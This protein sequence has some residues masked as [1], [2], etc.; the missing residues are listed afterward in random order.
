[1][2]GTLTARK[3]SWHRLTPADA[4]DESTVRGATRVALIISCA[5]LVAAIGLLDYWTGPD[6]SLAVLFLVPVV[7]AAW[8]AGRTQGI[9]VAL[10]A[11]MAWHVSNAL[12]FPA[13]SSI[14][15]LWNEVTYF[16]FF[17]VAAILA[18]RLRSAM[19][20]DQSLAITD[21]LTGAANGAAFFEATHLELERSRRTGQPVTIAL[22]GVDDFR[23]VVSLL[24]Q[25]QGDQALRHVADAL[26]WNLRPTDLLARLAGD[27]FGLLLP[28]TDEHTAVLLI[29]RL[30]RVAYQKT[31]NSGHPVTLSVGA[32][33]LLNP[34]EVD[35]AARLANVQLAAARTWCDGQF[36]HVVVSGNEQ[37]A[38]SD[39]END[40]RM[41]PRLPCNRVVRVHRVGGDCSTMAFA[42]V[43]DLSAE[44]LGLQAEEEYPNG[45]LLTV[46]ALYA[47][48][49]KTLLARVVRTDMQD[50]VRSHGCV[51]SSALTSTDLEPWL[52]DTLPPVHHIDDAEPSE[53]C[54]PSATSA[55][56]SDA[57]VLTNRS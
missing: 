53:I 28:K 57:L 18:A 44:G 27:E 51:L 19:V 16:G 49:A 45:A 4:T 54:S 13:R 1:M 22:L 29:T 26:R 37:N 55:A 5:L 7:G 24:G 31:Q 17:V 43:R 15:S 12:H 34:P 11:A 20:H 8:W 50:G 36:K 48:G 40:R 23:H 47:L 33:T 39:L 2:A 6:F 9:L 21:P 32:V 30:Q 41:A 42:M 10:A 25:P 46:E 14:P 56:D 38:P 3:S 52:G 35:E